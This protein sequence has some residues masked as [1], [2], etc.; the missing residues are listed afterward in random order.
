MKKTV[1]TRNS[2]QLIEETLTDG[3]TVYDVAIGDAV[4]FHASSDVEASELF[5]KLSALSFTITNQQ[6]IP[7]H[8]S[9]EMEARHLAG[10]GRD[11]D[12]ASLEAKE[13]VRRVEKFSMILRQF[14]KQGKLTTKKGEGQ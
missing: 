8:G 2:V 11:V 6:A 12:V 4:T 9:A 10:L 3:S 1:A 14:E 5:R 7:I 13:R